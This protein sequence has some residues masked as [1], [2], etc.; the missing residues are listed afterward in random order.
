MKM[1][2]GDGSGCFEIKVRTDR[3]NTRIAGFFSV[4]LCTDCAVVKNFVQL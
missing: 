1:A 3:A 2:I 4:Q